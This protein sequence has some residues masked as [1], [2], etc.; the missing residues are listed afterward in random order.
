MDCERRTC[1]IHGIHTFGRIAAGDTVRCTSIGGIVDGNATTQSIVISN[2]APIVSAVTLSPDPAYTND[3]ITPQ[4]PIPIWMGTTALTY[5]W[6]VDGT[7]VQSGAAETLAG[8]L[9]S[10]GQT[11]SVEVVANDGANNSTAGLASVI[12]NNTLLPHQVFPSHHRFPSEIRMR[13]VA[14]RE[15]PTKMAVRF[16]IHSHGLSMIPYNN[17]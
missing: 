2:A 1:G 9:F 16:L 13:S 14:R 8:T 10:K 17:A 15:A 12:I 7:Q 3:T 6:I 4:Q 5:T 11:V